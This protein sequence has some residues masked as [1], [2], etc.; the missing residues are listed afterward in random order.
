MKR[1]GFSQETSR[2]FYLPLLL[3]L[4]IGARLGHVIFYMPMEAIR[5]P[6]VIFQYWKGGLASHG[7]AICFIL[8]ILYMG[9]QLKI[10]VLKIADCLTPSIALG[11]ILVRFGNFFN[12]EI[13]GRTT[14]VAWA[15]K[16]PHYTYDQWLPVSQ[17]PSRHPSQLY[18]A[19]AGIIAM[20]IV[21][22]VDKI[23]GKNRPMGLMMGLLL[24]IYFGSRF[25][26]EFYKEY[27]VLSP[28]SLLTMGQYLSIPFVLLGF[29]LCYQSISSFRGSLL[30]R[31]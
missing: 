22:A 13:V 9:K 27:Q 16:F 2:R 4:L 10:P 24:I 8:V 19:I 26:L 15:I 7:A 31:T 5:N 1:M 11:I 18:E 23:Y 14:D 30:E 29:L 12:S 21:L 3:A 25:V 6:A 20:I 17:L 28:A